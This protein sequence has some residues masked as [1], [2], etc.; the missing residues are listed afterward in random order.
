MESLSRETREL[1]HE[2]KGSAWPGWCYEAGNCL[3]IFVPV[4]LQLGC[5]KSAPLVRI[6]WA[7]NC[8]Y[9]RADLECGDCKDR[10]KFQC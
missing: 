2:L 4:C 10:I 9:D 3:C 6:C 1:P 5:S 8:P 7:G